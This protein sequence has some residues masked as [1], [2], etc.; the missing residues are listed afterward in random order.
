MSYVEYVSKHA[1]P[2]PKRRWLQ[3]VIISGIPKL[4]R[5]HCIKPILQIYSGEVPL[6]TSSTNT[7]EIQQINAEE[8]AFGFSVGV[9]ID[10]DILIRCRHVRKDDSRVT[11]FRV[12][13]NTAFIEGFH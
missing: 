2:D 9:W 10:G 8:G 11:M 4:E 5:N 7:D 6:F 13:F 1:Q 3:R 12:F